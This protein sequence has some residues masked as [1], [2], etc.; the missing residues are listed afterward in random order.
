MT[1]DYALD[2]VEERE[3]IGSWTGGL[4]MPCRRTFDGNDDDKND[5]DDDWV[6]L[7]EIVVRVQVMLLLGGSQVSNAYVGEFQ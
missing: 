2:A 6:P 4:L 5:D 3:G 7:F 1:E